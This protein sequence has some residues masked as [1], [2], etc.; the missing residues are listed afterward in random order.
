MFQLYYFLLKFKF[1]A[2]AS[3]F[4]RFDRFNNKYNPL[5]QSELREIFL[6]TDNYIKGR[7]LA[8]M[9]KEVLN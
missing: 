1:K 3:M 5:G 4:E 2:D 8:E 9:T 7:Y 6:K